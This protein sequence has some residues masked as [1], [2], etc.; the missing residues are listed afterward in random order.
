MSKTWFLR[1]SLRN[2]HDAPGLLWVPALALAE[3]KLIYW[4]PAREG[5]KATTTNAGR[6]LHRSRNQC[7]VNHSRELPEIG[8]KVE[9]THKAVTWQCAFVLFG[10]LFLDSPLGNTTPRRDAS[11]RGYQ[12][13]YPSYLFWEYNRCSLCSH[14]S[15]WLR[16]IHP[17]ASNMLIWITPTRSAIEG[18]ISCFFGT[19][20]SGTTDIPGLHMHGL[21]VLAPWY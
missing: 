11:G 8:N 14:I 4:G 13:R 6:L 10:F 2:I 17:F 15:L 5:Y 1:N 20:D 3:F 19:T 7:V 12:Q 16:L 18:C 21:R 9:T